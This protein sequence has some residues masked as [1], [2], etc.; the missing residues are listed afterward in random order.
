MIVVGIARGVSGL[1]DKGISESE[2]SERF[3]WWFPICPSGEPGKGQEF[4]QTDE[5]RLM[6]VHPAIQEPVLR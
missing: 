2:A 5:W 3:G 6:T 4:A 1:N